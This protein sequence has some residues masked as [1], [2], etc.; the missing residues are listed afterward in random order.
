[1]SL[2]GAADNE[3]VDALKHAGE[4]TLGRRSAEYVLALGHGTEYLDGN[5][6]VVGKTGV[7]DGAILICYVESSS[8]KGCESR[9]AC[10]TDGEGSVLGI[11]V[12]INLDNGAGLYG[13]GDS[14]LNL[15]FAAVVSYRALDSYSG[16][17]LY[18]RESVG[19]GEVKNGALG[20]LCRRVGILVGNGSREALAAPAEDYRVLACLSGVNC[21]RINCKVGNDNEGIV[22]VV[23]LTDHAVERDLFA[24][25]IVC[26]EALNLELYELCSLRSLLTGVNDDGEEV[27]V[28]GG[29]DNDLGIL[30]EV[31]RES[32]RARAHAVNGEVLIVGICGNDDLSSCLN[33]ELDVCAALHIERVSVLVPSDVAALRIEEEVCPLESLTLIYLSVGR[34]SVGRAGAARALIE[35]V[36]GSVVYLNL[37]IIG[38]PSGEVGNLAVGLAEYYGEVGVESRFLCTEE[39]HTGDSLGESARAGVAVLYEL[40]GIRIDLDSVHGNET[41]VLATVGGLGGNVSVDVTL[42]ESNSRILSPGTSYRGIAVSNDVS[43]GGEATVIED[44]AVYDR[45]GLS[46]VHTLEGGD[47]ASVGLAVGD[48]VNLA[49]YEE[50][51]VVSTEDEVGSTLDVAVLK[52][53]TSKEELYG[54]LVTDKSGVS[55]YEAVGLNEKS[56]SSVLSVA[57]TEISVEDLERIPIVRNSKILDSTVGCSISDRYGGGRVGNLLKSARVG[58]AV[59]GVPLDHNLICTCAEALYGK[60]GNSDLELLVVVAGLDLDYLRSVSVCCSKEVES[61]LNRSKYVVAV[62]YRANLGGGGINESIDNAIRIRGGSR[63]GHVNHDGRADTA[64]RNGK[65]LSTLLCRVEAGDLVVS[66]LE[67]DGAVTALSH[68][69][70]GKAVGV[71][72]FAKEVELLE[73]VVEV[74]AVACRAVRNLLGSVE[75]E[76]DFAGLVNLNR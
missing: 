38:I 66:N 46:L 6:I 71:K 22:G 54:I 42:D 49:V 31:S 64:S 63:V 19:S 65:S 74:Y 5:E 59:Q 17:A 68:Y 58:N 47:V 35:V 16:I 52:I 56:K 8:V 23:S 28:T 25:L 13:E 51:G 76:L 60:V 39:S 9:L 36:V 45:V 62:T 29:K 72:R 53:L 32:S 14:T 27:A 50:S 34:K 44:R 2:A 1:M 75:A 11:S 20:D 55:H 7:N 67:L 48:R 30:C 57:L 15:N 18:C 26:V 12:R 41:L 33:R 4:I 61:L 40:K 69:Y 10:L 3:V 70:Y 24:Y 37:G 73:A 43:V 21:A